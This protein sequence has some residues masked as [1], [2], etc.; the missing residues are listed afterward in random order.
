MIGRNNLRLGALA[1]LLFA[2]GA[3]AQDL[4]PRYQPREQTPSERLENFRPPPPPPRR[5]TPVD[6]LVRTYEN[7]PVRP[8]F[9]PVSK[10]P[11]LQYNKKF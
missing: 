9:D 11:V 7:A 3:Q 10:Q 4:F 8:A 5:E 1:A 6:S 2:T